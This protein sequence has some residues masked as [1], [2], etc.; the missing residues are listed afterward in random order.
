MLERHEIE[1]FLTLAEELHFGRTADRLRVTTG[2]ISQTIKK[3]ERRVGAPLFERTSR[4]VQLTR[5]GKALAEDL[6]PLVS[7]IDDAFRKAID[8]GRGVS[9]VLRIG[10]VSAGAGQLLLRAVSLFGSRHPDCEVH[11]HE[12][13]IHE[14]VARLRNGDMD[15]LITDVLFA[16]PELDLVRGPVLLAEPRV[17]VVPAA[18]P[19]AKHDSISLEALAGYPMI[20]VNLPEEWRRDR[21]PSH[22]PGGKPIQRGPSA[23]TFAEIL[24]LVATGKGVFPAGAHAAQYYPRPDITYVPLHDA[25]PIR[26]G[27]VWV[28]TNTTE[29]VRAFV[30]AAY[31]ASPGTLSL[32]PPTAS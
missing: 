13:Q 23:N 32:H 31:D 30:K 25:A 3:L 5:I 10:F 17:L 19:L 28:G 7:G 11:I 6:A 26:W 18:H 15:V 21:I 16:D 14:A 27:P 4:Q 20:Q 29:R 1:A 12:A 24:S 8:A 2:R 9:G 22:T